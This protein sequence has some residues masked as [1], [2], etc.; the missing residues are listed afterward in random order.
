MESIKQNQN[1]NFFT[2]EIEDCNLGAL[3]LNKKS[4]IRKSKPHNQIRDLLKTNKCLTFNQL[5]AFGGI[6]NF[7]VV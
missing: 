1:A 2:I 5:H 6:F 4:T 7:F 3:C